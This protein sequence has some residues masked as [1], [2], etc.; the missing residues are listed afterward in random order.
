[1]RASC[2]SAS[3]PISSASRPSTPSRACWSAATRRQLG[4]LTRFLEQ[5]EPELNAAQSKEAAARA[6]LAHA[7]SEMA[8]WQQRWEAFSK[9]SA[10]ATRARKWSRRAS[11]RSSRACQRL[12][13][14]RERLAQERAQLEGSAS[15]AKPDEF[16]AAEQQARDRGREA[17]SELEA[18]L[19]S[20]HALRDAE[21]QGAAALDSPSRNCRRPRA[22]S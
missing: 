11:S 6:A 14:Q 20:M 10:E 7:E 22:N 5:A 1:M 13:A 2:A 12:K 16:A 18:A 4:E 17:Q 21:R 19:A 9:E 15:G 3:E 8:S